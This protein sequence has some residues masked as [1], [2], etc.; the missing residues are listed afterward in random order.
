[1]GSL[2]PTSS[3][4]YPCCNCQYLFGNNYYFLYLYFRE[5]DPVLEKPLKRGSLGGSSSPSV[6]PPRQT[7]PAQSLWIPSFAQVSE[8]F[9]LAHQ[10]IFRNFLDKA[11]CGGIR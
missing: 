10:N 2:H 3:H 1:M 11:I 9:P 6:E 4:P 8:P 7:P 5:V